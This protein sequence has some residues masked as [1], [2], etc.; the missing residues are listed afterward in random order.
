MQ[1]EQK[2]HLLHKENQSEWIYIGIWA[3]MLDFDISI[4]LKKYKKESCLILFHNYDNPIQILQEN[5]RFRNLYNHYKTLFSQSNS[6]DL[7][8]KIDQMHLDIQTKI[9]NISEVKEYCIYYLDT[10]T[11]IN[12]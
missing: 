12:M 5:L 2:A 1:K 3:D 4:N 7:K 11:I 6:K 10:D 8:E 9:E